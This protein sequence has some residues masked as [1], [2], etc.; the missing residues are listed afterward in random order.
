[1]ENSLLKHANKMLITIAYLC[2]NMEPLI[3]EKKTE[4]DLEREFEE[5]GIQFCDCGECHQ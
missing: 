5:N 4:D 1:M 2:N 3:N